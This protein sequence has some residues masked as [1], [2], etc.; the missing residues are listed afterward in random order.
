MGTLSLH[1]DMFEAR[2]WQ[3]AAPPAEGAGSLVPALFGGRTGRGRI[4]S[5]RLGTCERRVLEGG[6]CADASAS[7]APGAP[8]A[9]YRDTERAESS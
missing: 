6:F 4:K 8:S 5:G 3:D 9:D 2:Q 7:D 1:F